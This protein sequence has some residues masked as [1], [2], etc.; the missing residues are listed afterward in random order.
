MANCLLEND[1]TKTINFTKSLIMNHFKDYKNNAK[2]F[3]KLNIVV[4]KSNDKHFN[5]LITNLDINEFLDYRDSLNLDK[6]DFVICKISEDLYEINIINNEY[7]F[8]EKYDD[9][10]IGDYKLKNPTKVLVS[11]KD[12]AI[13]ICSNYEVEKPIRSYKKYYIGSPILLIL[14]GFVAYN[15]FRT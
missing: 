4:G 2:I 3:K 9:L 10:L 13:A 8:L 15:L 14:T 1:L 12:D 11:D 5:Y 7:K 6:I